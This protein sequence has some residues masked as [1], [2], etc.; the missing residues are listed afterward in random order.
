MPVVNE[1]STLSL[2]IDAQPAKKGA[3][4][5][6]AAINAIKAVV[7]GLEREADGTF[8]KLAGKQITIRADGAKQAAAD[9]AT[10]GTIAKRTEAQAQRLG[11]SIAS[12]MRASS[13]EA[14]ALGRSSMPSTTR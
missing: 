8:A 7:K 3:Q 14:A 5:F 9:V 12:A 1:T 10:V 13:K 6:T 2:R 4:D 11:L